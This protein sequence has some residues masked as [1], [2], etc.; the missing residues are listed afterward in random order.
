MEAEKATGGGEL[1]PT[2][3]VCQPMNSVSPSVRVVVNTGLT[4][5]AQTFLFHYTD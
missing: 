2:A 3:A 4:N 5:V 1:H